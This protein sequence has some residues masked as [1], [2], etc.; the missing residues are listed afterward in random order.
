MVPSKKRA[1]P[2]YGNEMFRTLGE[3]SIGAAIWRLGGR[4]RSVSAVTRRGPA[5]GCVSAVT[6]GDSYVGNAQA[7]LAQIEQP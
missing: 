6:P 2:F 4:S 1:M 3:R 7:V 5:L